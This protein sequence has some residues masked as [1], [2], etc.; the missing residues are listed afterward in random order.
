MSH[1]NEGIWIGYTPKV[2]WLSDLRHE[3][4]KSLRQPSL[5]CAQVKQ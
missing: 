5:R 3:V 4:N 1:V 2:R